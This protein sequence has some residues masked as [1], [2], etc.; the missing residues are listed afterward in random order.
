M[1]IKK[2]IL[3]T[4]ASTGIGKTSALYLDKMG[5]MVFA[6]VRNE[7]DKDILKK[8]ASDRLKPII[9]DVTKEKT[10][11]DAVEIISN[12][13]E[14]PLFGLVNN[15]GLGLRGPLEATS[16]AELRKLLEVNVIGLHAMCRAFLPLLRKNKGRIVN[17][18]SS[19]SFIAGPNGSSYAA[20]KFAVRAISESLR[21]EQKPFGMFVSLVAPSS[22]ASNIWDKGQAYREKLRIT[23]LPEVFEAYKPLFKAEENVVVEKIKPMDPLIVAKAVADGLT[24]KKPKNVYLVGSASKRA[25]FISRAP[26]LIREIYYAIVRAKRRFN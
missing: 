14:Y 16:E 15:A 10:I 2:S 6:G 1:E 21:I 22:I 3:M 13:V 9:L 17:I 24:S 4:G 11:S 7:K 5:F 19:A 12:E 18:G 8:E 25:Y 23:V 26:G 20:S